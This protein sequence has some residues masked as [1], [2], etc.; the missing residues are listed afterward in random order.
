SPAPTTLVIFYK[1]KPEDPYLY[2]RTFRVELGAGR[3][4]IYQRLDRAD[5]QGPLAILPGLK[6]GDYRIH[7]LEIRR[8]PLR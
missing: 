8:M 1:L 7:S 2:S 6:L 5:M 3:N 4:R